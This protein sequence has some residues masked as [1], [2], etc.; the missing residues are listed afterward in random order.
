MSNQ[1]RITIDKLI[2]LLCVLPTITF[3][4]AIIQRD[5]TL[6]N[7][8]IRKFFRLFNYLCMGGF[9]TLIIIKRKIFKESI[10]LAIIPIVYWSI[11]FFHAY[12]RPPIN[13]LI[14]VM[15]IL[16][17][18]TDKNNKCSIYKVYYKFIVIMAIAGIII[19]VS[20]YFKLPF[21]YD[22]VQYYVLGD[23][24]SY[25]NYKIGYLYV[26]NVTGVARLCGLFNEPGYFGT[27]I[28]FC[29]CL[30]QLNFKKK[31]NI[32]LLVAG[33]FTLSLAFFLIIIIYITVYS[34]QNPF[35]LLCLILL[36]CICFL[37]L[38]NI[39]VNNET[40]NTIL[41]RFRINEN[42]RLAGD[43]R[44]TPFLDREIK[45]MFTDRGYQLLFGYGT[46]YSSTLARSGLSYKKYLLH[47]GVVG[48]SFIYGIPFLTAC[49]LSKKNLPNLL[50]IMCFF[51]S[52][53]QRPDLYMLNYFV[54]LFGGIEY[55]NS[56]FD[57]KKQITQK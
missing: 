39:E 7:D 34:T 27:I 32:I 36:G 16:F 48:L 42:G 10:L 45:K 6:S 49:H 1:K 56:K 33:C 13:F 38:Q 19:Y 30:E 3:G 9:L 28:G 11:C 12:I 25:F 54:I 47:Y 24:A 51:V 43:N 55:L 4:L 17:L 2:V 21:P 40:I 35:R 20:Y 18:L 29:L 44:S 5:S 46:G 53:Y 26:S 37:V 23:N 57:T 8:F 50:F 22:K 52:L 15:I 14:T 31:E 41:T